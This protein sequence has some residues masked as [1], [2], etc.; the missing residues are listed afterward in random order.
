MGLQMKQKRA[1]KTY[2]CLSI[3]IASF[4]GYGFA[5][6]AATKIHTEEVKITQK[7]AEFEKF[8]DEQPKL[9]ADVKLEKLLCVKTKPDYAA[10][11]LEVA[12][13]KTEA[14]QADLDTKSDE[15]E[16]A[17][18]ELL[19]TVRVLPPV[20]TGIVVALFSLCAS[21]GMLMSYPSL[22]SSLEELRKRLME[23]SQEEANATKKP[24]KGVPQ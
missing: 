1:L 2:L 18:Q 12:K 15:V 5:K 11:C 22:K 3:G 14:L 17:K 8:K 6:I 24:T 4:V 21:M 7:V 23:K 10:G 20:P 13:K 16:Q 19:H 9:L